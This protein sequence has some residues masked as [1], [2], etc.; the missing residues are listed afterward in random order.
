MQ[1]RE[2]H[3]YEFDN[4]CVDVAE[5]SLLRNGAPVQLTPKAFDTLLVLVMRSGHL[6][7]KDELLKEVWPDT[8]VE[9][10]TLAQNISTL[11]K[12]LSQEGNGHQYIE[13][14]P[15]HGY[16]FVYTV[17]VTED[18]GPKLI[19]QQ[20]TS[21]HI[22]IEEEET[23]DDESPS[24]LNET[25]TL[26]NKPEALPVASVPTRRVEL[27]LLLVIALLPAFAGG[28]YLWK[29]NSKPV[30]AV[31]Q[32]N[33]I[34]VLPFRPLGADSNDEFLGLGMAD[35]TIIKLSNF[36]QLSVLP[37]SAV[38]KFTGHE[39]DALAAGREL[40]VDAVLNGTVQRL[41]ERVRVTVQLTRLRDGK[42]LWSQIF[43]EHYTNIFAIQDSISEQVANALALQI[44]GDKE[45]QIT[46]RYTDN[47]EAYQAYLMGIYFWNKRSKEGLGKAIEYFQRAIASDPNYAL[48]YAGLADSY[49]LSAYYN[50][51][52]MDN[53]EALSKGSAAAA[54]GV[55]LDDSLAEGQTALAMSQT[56]YEHNYDA[57]M[58]SLRRA[59]ELN[60]N[61]ALAHQRYAWQLAAGPKLD[62]A[63]REM[64]RAQELDPL[65]ATNNSALGTLLFY[66][67]QFDESLRYSRRA[68]EL[69]PESPLM[70]LNL[71]MVYEQKGMYDE[72]IDAY[73]KTKKLNGV[74]DVDRMA[75]IAH[76][77]A[78]SGQK[79]EAKKMLAD[80]LERSKPEVHANYNI[81]LIYTALGETDQAFDWLN[82]A[83]AAHS[84]RPVDLR[85]DPQLDPLRSDPRFNSIQRSGSD[86]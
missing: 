5:R 56:I 17:R 48:A 8:F 14:V 34:A 52:L 3:L 60:P 37:T 50:Y 11:R 84:L 61:Y 35:A 29:A 4:F 66:S 25:K 81:A 28:L 57:A 45:K 58:K 62:E 70:L 16:R 15:K 40:G 9:E 1:V 47:A 13:T 65:S 41:G 51:D 20:Q 75:A 53:K 49:L 33:S 7:E 31:S 85:Y 67:R 64:R 82:K 23:R 42:L 6:V 43:D 80:L 38:F 36:H 21:A 22:I 30:A 77:L 74:S 79:A 69:D 27:K 18:Q 54:K 46:K 19:I 39:N 24:A 10:A 83:A 12:I 76:A 86:M 63:V 73:Q 2:R 59:I 55:Q 71:G 68:V 32:I 72:A 78:A 26:I 44:T